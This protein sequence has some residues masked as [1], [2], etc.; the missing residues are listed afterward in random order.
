MP[1]MQ[2]I[3]QEYQIRVVQDLAE[4]HTLEAEWNMLTRS[5]KYHVPFLCYDWFST[6]LRHFLKEDKLFILLVYKEDH[7]SAIASFIIK[8]E[9]F[10]GIVN[11]RKIELIGNVHSPIRNFVFGELKKS[12]MDL[13]LKLFDF[14]KSDY[15]EWDILEL[16]SIPEEFDSFHVIRNAVDL[17]GFKNREYF[18]FND[19]V[20][21]EIS[22]SSDEYIS[23]QPRNLK[24]EIGKRKRRLERRG[25]LRFEIERDEK[26]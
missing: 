22:Y 18:C 15:T 26:N 10:K 13:L 7:L 1:V 8:T 11:T 19:W 16:D 24:K 20:L 25:D 2:E 14:F 5:Y 9:K 21:D 12:R 17:I 3:R 6:W 23:R 4:F